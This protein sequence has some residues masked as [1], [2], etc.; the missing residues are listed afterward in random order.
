M[1]FITVI[2]SSELKI[3]IICWVSSCVSV[4]IFQESIKIIK[5]IEIEDV[6]G[7]N[8]FRVSSQIL[9]E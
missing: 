3:R 6:A 4:K 8:D 2:F 5:I 1:H 7:A 9:F